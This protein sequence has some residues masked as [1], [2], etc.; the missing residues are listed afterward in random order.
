MKHYYL[1][2]QT[3]F[4]GL[5]RITGYYH[6]LI[7]FIIPLYVDSRGDD[8]TI[9]VENR[10][11]DATYD[12]PPR[13][14]VMPNDRVLYI[15]QSVFGNRINFEKN[16]QNKSCGK[17]WLDN[18]SRLNLP[19]QDILRD[20]QPPWWGANFVKN[21]EHKGIWGDYDQSHYTY[22][23]DGM[24]KQFNIKK[25]T[26]Y[27]VTI[28]RRGTDAHNRKCKLPTNAVDLIKSDFETDLPKRVVDFSSMSFEETIRTC[29]ETKVLIGQH[30]AGFANSVFME[31]GGKIIEY[32]PIKV[33]CYY[34]LAN[35]CGL[36]YERTNLRDD[37]INIFDE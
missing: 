6:L 28:T 36:S 17:I 19:L 22:F 33:P 29:L 9:H 23:R 37:I 8:I 2:K 14:G 32:G 26:Q 15:I 11:L 24:L 21:P 7:D 13:A 31:P 25:P 10:C 1:S 12:R 27:Y 3:V 16:K 34:I 30:G 20:Q 35:G 5:G 4:S 18:N